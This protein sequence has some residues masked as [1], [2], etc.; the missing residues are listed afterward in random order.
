M[1]TVPIDLMVDADVLGRQRTGD[2]THVRELLRVLG[3]CG[4]GLRVGAVARH[5]ELVP[6]GVHPFDLKPLNQLSRMTWELP[7]FLRRVA[8]TLAHFQYVVPPLY[9]GRS[10][11]T[12]HDM[13][14]ELL[15]ELED[16]F[17]GWAL[18]RAVPMAVRR[19]E[20][21]FTV[22]EWTKRDILRHYR[23]REE[24]VVVTLNGVSEVFGPCGPRLDRPPF[25]LFVGALRPRKDPVAALEC[26]RLLGRTDLDLVMV[27]PDKG[28]RPQV[29]AL[30]ERHGMSRRVHLLGHVTTAELAALYRS[31]QCFVFPSRY[32][33]FGLPVLEAMASGTPVVASSS[34]AIP[35]VAGDA[36]LLVPP[37]SPGDL[38]DAVK[39]ALSDRERLVEEGLRRAAMFSWREVGR[40]TLD[41]CLSVL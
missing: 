21:V 8:P 14:F 31:A 36:C 10:V 38:A 15:P 7:A 17:D 26:Y 22:S 19:A 40:R 34:G 11:V 9:R 25:L 30:V 16:R 35:E 24:K 5:P 18:R 37:S 20:L 29:E 2:E 3:D 4:K 1:T 41:A 13:S 32:E 33:G 39:V 27:G 23:L 6:T 12:V 28:L